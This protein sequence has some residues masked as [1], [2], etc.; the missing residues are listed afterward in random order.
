MAE[1][2]IIQKTADAASWG[3]AY[4]AN[5][6]LVN[7]FTDNIDLNEPNPELY[8]QGNEKGYIDYPYAT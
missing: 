2:L 8:F 7:R 6:D 5:P 3:Q 4:I 1:T